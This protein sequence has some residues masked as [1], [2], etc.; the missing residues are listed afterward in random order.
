[1]AT[2]EWCDDV[3]PDALRKLVKVRRWCS[4]AFFKLAELLLASWLGTRDFMPEAL[5][6]LV[7]VR[8]CSTML[9]CKAEL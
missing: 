8:C 3:L 1:M 5:R 2:Q 9:R 6:R 7:K 4:C